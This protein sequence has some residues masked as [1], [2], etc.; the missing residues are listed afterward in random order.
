M[1]RHAEET[2]QSDTGGSGASPVLVWDG[3][4]IGLH[5]SGW[6][7]PDKTVKTIEV[8]PRVGFA[9]TNGLVWQAHGS[10]WIGFGWNWF[11]WWPSDAGTDISHHRQLVFRLRIEATVREQRPEPKGFLVTLRSSTGSGKRSTSTVQFARG[12]HEDLGN[13]EWHKITV[14]LS[15][16]VGRDRA[17]GFDA[18]HAWEF[19]LGYWS[20]NP[21]TFTAYVDD[22]GFE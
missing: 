1:A 10:D 4:R 3:D 21:T 7:G 19:D 11:S 12:A 5:A 13:G 2:S 9:Q 16:L 14:L 22:I 6:S 8:V 15:D 20:K 18:Q 17:Q